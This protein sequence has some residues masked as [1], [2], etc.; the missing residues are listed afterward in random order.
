MATLHSGAKASFLLHCITLAVPI[1]FSIRQRDLI[2]MLLYNIQLQ[3]YPLRLEEVLSGVALTDFKERVEAYVDDVVAVGEDEEDL[4]II[5]VITRQF[6]DMSGAILYRSYEMA[7]LGLGGWE[8]RKEW[9]SEWVSAPQ[10]L[11]TF[12]VTYTPTLGSTI[13]LLWKDCL[14]RVQRAIHGWKERHVPFLRER[15]D[16]L[17]SHILRKLWYLAQ[18][19][20]LP[21]AVAAKATRLAG[22]F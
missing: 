6:E 19:L 5:D 4:L 15:R 1:T 22:F 21:Q 10:Q 16:V 18:I 14:A 7:I 2:A 13:S 20:P 8:E 12:G 11:K 9:P 17:E 3:P